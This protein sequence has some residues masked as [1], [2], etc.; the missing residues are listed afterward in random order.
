MCNDIVKCDRIERACFGF[1]MAEICRIDTDPESVPGHGGNLLAQLDTMNVKFALLS[2]VEKEARG[3]PDVQD[4]SFRD[5][6][7]QL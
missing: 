4:D 2:F 7:P 6:F 3:A 1:D 5:V